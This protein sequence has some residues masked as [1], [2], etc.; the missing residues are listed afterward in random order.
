MVEFSDFQCPACAELERRLRQ[1]RQRF[2]NKFAMVYRHFP[3]SRHRF[4]EAAAGASECAASQSRFEEMHTALF[5]NVDSIGVA[6]WDWFAR[7]AKV[8]NLAA[9]RTC[10][11][12][13]RTDS[14]VKRDLAAATRLGA[15]ATPTFLIDGKRYTGAVPQSLLDSIVVRAIRGAQTR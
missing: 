11:S 1:T 14:I 7:K 8:A 12:A 13:P 6:S 15:T 10:L 2:G 4:A 5:D 9:F 3:L